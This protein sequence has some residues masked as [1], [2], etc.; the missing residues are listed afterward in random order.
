MP[1]YQ[2]FVTNHHKERRFYRLRQGFPDANRD[3]LQ[4]VFQR[5]PTNPEATRRAGVAML[6]RF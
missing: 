5:E 4:P 6:T 1:G 2:N 3:R